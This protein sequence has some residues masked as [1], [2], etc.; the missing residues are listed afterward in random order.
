MNPLK[1]MIWTAS[2]AF[3]RGMASTQRIRLVAK[4]WRKQGRIMTHGV[5][6]FL[7]NRDSPME[8]IT[9]LGRFVASEEYGT[10]SRAARETVFSRYSANAWASHYESKFDDGQRAR[11]RW[12]Q[13]GSAEQPTIPL[14]FLAEF[15]GFFRQC[16]HRSADIWR[17]VAYGQRAVRVARYGW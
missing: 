11:R 2:E 6:G 7:C 17:F 4:A 3:P 14:E 9:A 12:P 16:K 15:P 13:T 10:V 8:Y 1:V 5:D